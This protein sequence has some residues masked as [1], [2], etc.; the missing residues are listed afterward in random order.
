MRG[1]GGR[2]EGNKDILCG[3]EQTADSH[4]PHTGSQSIAEG[5]GLVPLPS[6]PASVGS[7][8]D[9]EEGFAN[10]ASELAEWAEFVARRGRGLIRRLCVGVVGAL[11]WR[12]ITCTP[13]PRCSEWAR[14]RMDS[15]Q[16]LRSRRRWRQSCWTLLSP[17]FLVSSCACQWTPPQTSGSCSTF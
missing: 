15:S 16:C 13:Q 5:A 10:M 6:A 11:G 3:D 7:V 8:S 12:V 1:P 9:L 2:K 17:S 14:P 4:S